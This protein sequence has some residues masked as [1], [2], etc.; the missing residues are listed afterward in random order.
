[1]SRTCIGMILCVVVAAYVRPA[2]AVPVF[3]HTDF[4]ESA[5]LNYSDSPAGLIAPG[6]PV[7][8]QYA[9]LGVLHD[10]H[11]TTPPGPAGMS[12]LSGLPG[13]EAGSDDIPGP[14]LEITFDI[15]VTG[16]GAFYLMGGATD[17]IILS[18]FDAE[19]NLIETVVVLPDDMPMRPGPFGF[20]EGFVGILTDTA[21]AWARFDADDLAFVI[22]DLHVVPE[23]ATAT[24]AVLGALAFLFRRNRRIR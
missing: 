13:L 4:P 5:I 23:P 7:V 15:P 1:M 8:N 2:R 20:N 11:T 10:G 16:V 18:V 3:D 17:P 6:D 9:S 19:N 22:D 21:I 12:S 24:L 14:F